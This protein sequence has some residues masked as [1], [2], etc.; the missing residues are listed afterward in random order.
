[1]EV[2]NIIFNCFNNH[3]RVLLCP[4]REIKCLGLVL[5][6]EIYWEICI[7]SLGYID[8]PLEYALI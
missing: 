7:F 8:K 1:M 2:K 5:S 4:L 3:V 6:M